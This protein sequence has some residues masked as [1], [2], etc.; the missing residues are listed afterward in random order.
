MELSLPQL[1]AVQK[2]IGLLFRRPVS[3]TQDL[4]DPERLLDPTLRTDFV[5]TD[6]YRWG[7][8]NLAGVAVSWPDPPE[9]RLYLSEKPTPDFALS[10]QRFF[11]GIALRFF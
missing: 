5:S 10:L 9:V 8:K 3:R 6:A 11:P 7:V 4:P 1:V 2:A